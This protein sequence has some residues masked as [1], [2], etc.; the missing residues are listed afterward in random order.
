MFVG[1]LFLAVR[2]LFKVEKIILSTYFPWLDHG[3]QYKIKVILDVF[4]L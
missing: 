1:S 2:L 4:V 3:I